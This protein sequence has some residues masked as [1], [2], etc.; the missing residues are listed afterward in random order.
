MYLT[1]ARLSDHSKTRNLRVE[2]ARKGTYASHQLLWKLFPQQESRPFL[3]RQEQGD[4]YSAPKGEPCFYLLSS[5]LPENLDGLVE[6]ES[7][8]FQPQLQQGD[9]LGFTI[10]LNPTV[11]RDKKRHDVLMDAR[12]QWLKQEAEQIGIGSQG[13]QGNL[14]SELLDQAK[15]QDIERWQK[16]LLERVSEDSIENLNSRKAILNQVLQALAEQAAKDWWQQ[17]LGSMGINPENSEVQQVS[18][19]LQHQLSGKTKEASFSSVE[20]T[21]RITVDQPDTFLEKVNTGIGRAKAFGCG[22]MLLRRC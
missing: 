2:L 3:F 20:L 6:T 10:R 14:K 1:K 4:G 17:R 21:G 9:Q 18:G 8:P 13:S 11:C 22:L 5:H 7:K 16:M 12:R 15:D 19:Y